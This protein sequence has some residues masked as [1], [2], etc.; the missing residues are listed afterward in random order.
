[1]KILKKAGLL[2]IVVALLCCSLFGCTEPEQV[3]VYKATDWLS[4]NVTVR[5]FKYD[6]VTNKWG[7]GDSIYGDDAWETVSTV[8]DNYVYFIM[9]VKNSLVKE[10]NILLSISMTV[11]AESDMTTTFSLYSRT[12]PSNLQ[13]QLVTCK[14]GEEKIIAFNY[15]KPITEV[16]GKRESLLQGSYYDFRLCNSTFTE[17]EQVT[18]IPVGAN[19]VTL[20]GKNYYEEYEQTGVKYKIT[21][22]TF[23]YRPFES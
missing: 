12:D 11:V 19:R 9:P 17:Y 7:L 22:I 23:V 5:K 2:L 6:D 14:A 8:A 3:Q 15:D 16:F 21:T 13:S 10:E 18:E 4:G 20:D 1:M